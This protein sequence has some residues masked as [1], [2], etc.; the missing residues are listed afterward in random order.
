MCKVICYSEL[1]EHS[2]TMAIRIHIQIPRNG[3]GDLKLCS[4]AVAMARLS[5]VEG[6]M[7][8]L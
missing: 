8:V 2:A 6:T 4:T 5:T 7:R 1:L 3:Y